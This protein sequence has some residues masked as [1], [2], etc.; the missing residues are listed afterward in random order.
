[1]DDIR[2]II[3]RMDP[4]QAI[5]E[6]ATIVKELFSHVSEKVRMNFINAFTGDTDS[7]SLS[8]LVHL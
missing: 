6:I 8:G 1:M 7:E 3:G 2:K 4:E 5:T